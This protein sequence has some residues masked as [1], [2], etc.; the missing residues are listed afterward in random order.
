MRRAGDVLAARPRDRNETVIARFYLRAGENSRALDIL[1]RGFEARD[2]NL[3]SVS[4]HPDSDPLR[5]EPRFQELL[6]RMKL[7]G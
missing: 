7:P 5:G 2:P 3:P 6:R 1:E 4:V